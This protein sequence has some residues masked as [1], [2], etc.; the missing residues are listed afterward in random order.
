M[1]NR[2]GYM[3][4]Y[5]INV[6]KPRRKRNAKKLFGLCPVCNEKMERRFVYFNERKVHKKCKKDLVYH[7]AGTKIIPRLKRMENLKSNRVIL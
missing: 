2:E 4:E 6:L 3:Q 5:Y 1:G 7:L